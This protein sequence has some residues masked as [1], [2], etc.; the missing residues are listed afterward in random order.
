VTRKAAASQGGPLTEVWLVWLREG[1]YGD[2]DPVVARSTLPLARDW[3][4]EHRKLHGA[5]PLQWASDTGGTSRRR[6]GEDFHYALESI[7][8]SN[9]RPL[10]HPAGGALSGWEP[11]RWWRVVAADGSV[12][13]ETSDEAEAFGAVRPGDKLWRQWVQRSSEWRVV[14]PARPGR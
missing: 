11:G 6:G 2:S 7:P 13:C 9:T 3:C 1:T 5:H 12:W 14:D 10:E 8:F 4:N